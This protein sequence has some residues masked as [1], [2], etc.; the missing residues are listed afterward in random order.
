MLRMRAKL[1]RAT[2]S[3]F[4]GVGLARLRPTVMERVR[5][6]FRRA[7]R[8]G[9]FFP[10][11]VPIKFPISINGEPQSQAARTRKGQSYGEAAV[12]FLIGCKAESHQLQVLI[13]KRSTKVGSHP[14]T[15]NEPR[16][17][18]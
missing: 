11:A 17:I 5:E 2:P 4:E 14:G 13:T 6:R 1:L 9:W 10:G 3:N 18:V 16:T 12:L 7:E 8:N 15:P